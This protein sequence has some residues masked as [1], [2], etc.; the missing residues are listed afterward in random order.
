MGGN[1]IC[2]TSNEM[3]NAV[4]PHFAAPE[5]RDLGIIKS[6]RKRK[7]RLIVAPFPKRQK[8]SPHF[9]FDPRAQ[10]PLTK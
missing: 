4:L 1:S 8:N 3:K 6:Q 9:F 10:I 2:A 5:N 7:V